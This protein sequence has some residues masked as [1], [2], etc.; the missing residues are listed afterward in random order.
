LR[1]PFLPVRRSEDAECALRMARDGALWNEHFVDHLLY[2][3]HSRRWWVAQWVV[4]RTERIRRPLGL[5]IVNRLRLVSPR[6]Q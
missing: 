6:A 4:D 5:Q 2:H 1:Y 3:Y